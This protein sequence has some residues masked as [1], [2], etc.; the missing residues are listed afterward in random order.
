MEKVIR[1]TYRETAKVGAGTHRSMAE[2]FELGRQLYNAALHERIDCYRKTGRSIT[3]VDQ[4]KS[5]TTV[6]RDHPEYRAVSVELMRSV[7]SR[8]DEGFAHFFRRCGS[9]GGK[10]GFPRFK[11]KH[12]GLR[13][14]STSAFSA[15]RSG[16]RFAIHIKGL[17]RFLVKRMPARDTI[18]LVRI[19]RTALRAV[20]QFCCR[21]TVDVAPSESEPVGI[22]VGVEK[23]AVLSTGEVLPRRTPDNRRRKRLQRGLSKARRGSHARAKKRLAYA[24]ECERV[25]EREKQYIHRVASALVKRYPNLV[26]ERLNIANLVRSAR[27]TKEEPGRHV[28]QKSGLNRSIL[29][30]RWGYFVQLLRYKAARAGGSVE[31]VRPHNTSKTCSGCGWKH[32]DLSLETRVFDCEQCGLSLDRD[33]NAAINIRNRSKLWLSGG[34]GASAPPD[35]RPGVGPSIP[36]VAAG[37]A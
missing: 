25:A 36:L 11:S 30:Q 37:S 2:T 7:L 29:E 23:Q 19:V 27:G 14:L 10:P 15:R 26:V 9:G 5:L 13:S 17:G 4:F 16:N 18:R 22:D 24:K 1:R 8:V 32:P 33:H 6:R 21:E 31:R 35:T 28:K 3:K 12:R 34:K 20:V